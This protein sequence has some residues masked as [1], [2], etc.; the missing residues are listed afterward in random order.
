LWTFEEEVL[1]RD[2]PPRFFIALAGKFA[3]SPYFLAPA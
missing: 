1:P 3:A 2:A